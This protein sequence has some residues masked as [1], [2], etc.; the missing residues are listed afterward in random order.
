[1][2]ILVLVILIKP[3]ERRRAEYAAR[4]SGV[5]VIVLSVGVCEMGVRVVA[6]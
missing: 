4:I 1:M 5:R 6:I 2:S 3:E